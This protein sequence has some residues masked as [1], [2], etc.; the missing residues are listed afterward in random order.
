M[1][2]E[3]NIKFEHISYR[4]TFFKRLARDESWVTYGVKAH[5]RVL[6]NWERG[7]CVRQ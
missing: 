7:S 6:R 4:I 1:L 3:F 5:W 2:R